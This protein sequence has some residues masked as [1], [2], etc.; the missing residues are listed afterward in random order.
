MPFPWWNMQAPCL[1]RLYRGQQGS[2]LPRSLVLM[3][4]M[5]RLL[6]SRVLP[7]WTTSSVR[8]ETMLSAGLAHSGDSG[9]V[10]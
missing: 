3:G 9:N 10:P 7:D 2:C 6:G 5:T 8:T 4:V 1:V